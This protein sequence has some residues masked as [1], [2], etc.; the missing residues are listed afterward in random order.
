LEVGGEKW[1]INEAGKNAIESLC[2]IKKYGR[3]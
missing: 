1:K 2:E 3:K